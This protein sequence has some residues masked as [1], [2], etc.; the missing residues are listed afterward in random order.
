MN[1]KY[2]ELRNGRVMR[3]I[4]TDYPLDGNRHSS[5]S[6][7]MEITNANPQPLPGW[8]FNKTLGIFGPATEETIIF[9]TA[10]E[11]AAAAIDEAAGQA[12][13]RYIT[14]IP[15]QPEVY[16]EKYEQAIDFLSCADQVRY[17]DYPLLD[18]ECKILDVPMKDIAENIIKRRSEWITKM[19]AIESLRLSGKYN[20]SACTTTNEVHKLK[21]HIIHKLSDLEHPGR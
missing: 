16:R 13:L 8:R 15:G 14:D 2:A 9:E 19:T 5:R 7:W 17:A 21:A 10:R 20:L 1:Y 4:D 3:V 12:R 6:E 18:I 11:A